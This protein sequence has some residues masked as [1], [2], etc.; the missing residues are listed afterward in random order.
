MPWIKRALAAPPLEARQALVTGFGARLTGLMPLSVEQGQLA[1]PLG[2]PMAAAVF[3]TQN[4]YYGIFFAV[5]RRRI[6][7]DL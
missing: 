3:P 4:F 5:T 7:Y 6:S 1:L 2:Y